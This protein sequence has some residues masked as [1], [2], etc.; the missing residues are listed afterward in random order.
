MDDHRRIALVDTRTVGDEIEVPAQLV[1]F[2]FGNHL[3]SATLE[4]DGDGQIISYEEYYPY[5]S[6]S[7]QA[8]RSAAEVSL[9]R[10]RYTG[11]ER[12]A[13]T[14]L[15]YHGA[16][17][18]VSWLGR[19][20]SCDPL[21]L[22]D[23]PNLYQYT[24]SSPVALVDVGGTNS[25]RPLKE[26][27]TE[28]VEDVHAHGFTRIDHAGNE[29][30]QAIA[31]R[32]V[33]MG[34]LS[35]KGCDNKTSRLDM[36][37]LG[38]AIYARQHH[39]EREFRDAAIRGRVRARSREDDQLSLHQEYGSVNRNGL[40]GP[41]IVVVAET[42]A[43]R[44]HNQAARER[45]RFN[46]FKIESDLV[47][48]IGGARAAKG[49]YSPKVTN[50]PYAAV[51]RRD[52]ALAREAHQAARSREAKLAQTKV[53]NAEVRDM[54]KTRNPTGSRQNCTICVGAVAS[55]LDGTPQ[56]AGIGPMPNLQQFKYQ[57]PGL[58]P[59]SLREVV[60]AMKAAG[61][62]AQGVLAGDWIDLS[63]PSA[64]PSSHAFNLYNSNGTVLF[65]DAHNLQTAV[66]KLQSRDGT[67]FFMNSHFTLLK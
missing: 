13:E 5:G 41:G 30:E 58:R 25:D 14:G 27:M 62:G 6:T 56:Y 65:L 44:E 47:A 49:K 18:Y 11:M 43:Q 1:R 8:G 50:E 29:L 38:A 45:A 24:R 31:N 4:L 12:D 17:Y 28:V 22:E 67:I 52:A 9:K 66:A 64:A 34:A 46:L 16:R 23:G 53:L 2:Q 63:K 37:D 35:L 20:A 51:A 7:Y 19:W 32:F 42:R 15:N 60:A 26:T 61:P 55:T 36:F 40:V 3:G 59:T 33:D 21:G 57:Y 54:V 10:Y 39:L 48:S